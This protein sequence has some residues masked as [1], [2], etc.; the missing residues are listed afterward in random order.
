MIYFTSDLHFNHDR[1]F[2]YAPRGFSSVH[3]MNNAI[4]NRW[5]SLVNME[6]EVYILGDVM[7][8]D[9]E[10]AIKMFKNL[11]GSIHIIRGNHDTNTRMDLYNDCYNVV[12]VTEGQYLKIEGQNFYLCHYPTMTSNLD[13]DKPLKTRLISLAGHCHTK[14]KFK[15][16]DKGLIYHVEV[17]A[18]NNKPVSI[19]TILEDIKYFISLDIND[20][21]RLCENK[22]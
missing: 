20:Q 16:M 18:H 7:L 15:D 1:E 11:K 21:K 8:G 17:D 14:N 10:S 22:I 13:S 12:E 2:V 5:N 4:I 9:N 19:D 6:D 3:E